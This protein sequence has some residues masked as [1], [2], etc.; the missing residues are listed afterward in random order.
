MA[1]GFRYRT[2]ADSARLGYAAGALI[3]VLDDLLTAGS[4]PWSKTTNGTNDVTYQAPGG[5]QVKLHVAQNYSLSTNFLVQVYAQVGADPKF[6]I[7]AQVSN[8]SLGAVSLK[9]RETT[10]TTEAYD[11][12]WYGL[13]TD[14]FMML[15]V[16]P[17][18]TLIGGSMMICGD[19]PVLDA[20]DPGLCVI[21]CSTSTTVSST[22]TTLESSITN[23]FVPAPAAVLEC[24]Y[25][26]VAADG[27]TLSVPMHL[28]PAFPHGS[29]FHR[30]SDSF[31]HLPM[32]RVYVATSELQDDTGISND[33]WTLRG[34]L[35]YIF[36]S[37]VNPSDLNWNDT[38]SDGNGATY[39]WWNPGDVYP[40]L[41][42]TS[43]DEALP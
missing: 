17:C 36:V 1:T 2:D 9:C 20:A 13:R 10:V 21:A 23:S 12:R 19:L 34:Y 4:N 16:G 6:P 42:M 22:S 27:T 37:P 40:G 30:L 7:A 41:W 11:Q 8:S 26:Y 32:G 15:A 31:G 29:S 38:F 43:D 18:D 24:G 5:S 28:I 14:R 39:Q 25:A 35:P 33:F 3:T